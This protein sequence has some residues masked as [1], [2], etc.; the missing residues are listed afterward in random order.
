MKYEL[1]RYF[2]A[3]LTLLEVSFAASNFTQS[4]LRTRRAVVGGT[5][6]AQGEFP[7][8]VAVGRCGG[9]LISQNRV[10]TAAHCICDPDRPRSSVRIG[11]TTQT[12]GKEVPVSCARIH[13][14]YGK[15][16]CDPNKAYDIAVLQLAESVTDVTFATLNTD[17]SIP[18]GSSDV[19][20][21]GFGQTTPGC[22]T[23]QVSETLNKLVY[24]SVSKDDCKSIKGDDF[25]E[26]L[27]LCAANT[28]STGVCFHDSGGPM[29]DSSGTVQYGIAVAGPEST[30]C[31]TGGDP[32]LYTD[33]AA[34][35]AWITEQLN[36][37]TCDQS[38]HGGFREWVG[39][40]SSGALSFL[41]DWV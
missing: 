20:V 2:V 40:I 18:A 8:F 21:L 24:S 41:N 5:A 25:R 13:P 1:A 16:G 34:H 39:E 33:V 10:L 12:D 35:N 27:R 9:T 6:V 23:T 7:F 29:L 15:V 17:T 26:D 31:A 28:E 11:P 22:Y 37:N 3:A 4:H 14:D 38:F 36:D 19:T 32:D 30:M